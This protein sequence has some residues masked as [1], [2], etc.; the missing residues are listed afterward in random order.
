MVLVGD[1][2]ADHRGQTMK[3]L[4]SVDLFVPPK[5]ARNTKEWLEHAKLIVA[6]ARHRA[7]EMAQRREAPPMKRPS[8]L[9]QRRRLAKGWSGKS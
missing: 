1:T 5:R 6:A 2:R 9:L 3:M 7:V 4:T 8:T